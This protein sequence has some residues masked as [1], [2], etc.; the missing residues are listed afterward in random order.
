M[1]SWVAIKVI[2][3]ASSVAEYASHDAVTA[4]QDTYLASSVA[5][6]ASHDAVTATQVIY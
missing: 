1:C 3:S 6:L 2:Y 4:T 5:E